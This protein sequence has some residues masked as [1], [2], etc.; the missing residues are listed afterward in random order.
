M[1]KVGNMLTRAV[2]VYM[3]VVGYA[4]AKADNLTEAWTF[5]AFLLFLWASIRDDRYTKKLENTILE[6]ESV[7]LRTQYIRNR[8]LEEKNG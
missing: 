6:Q 7:L 3:G 2:V 5:I 1:K 8:M 4:M